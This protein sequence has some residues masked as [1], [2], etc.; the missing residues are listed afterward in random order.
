MEENAYEKNLQYLKNRKI[1]KCHEN[2]I[3]GGLELKRTFLLSKHTSNDG[4]N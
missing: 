4:I 3:K 1:E 2:E